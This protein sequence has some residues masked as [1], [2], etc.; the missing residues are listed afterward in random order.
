MTPPLLESYKD[1]TGQ[2]VEIH[3]STQLYLYQIK[4]LHFKENFSI[5]SAFL[6]N[7]PQTVKHVPAQAG[8]NT[9][10]SPLIC[11]GSAAN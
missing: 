9:Q 8:S 1:S 4:Q 7:F 2:K 5:L 10:E 11:D 3:K 6:L